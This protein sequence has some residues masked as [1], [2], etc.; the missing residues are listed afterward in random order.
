MP[1]RMGDVRVKA[2]LTTAVDEDLVRRG[3]LT[4]EQ[5]RT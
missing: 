1:S 4:P 5:V 2:R 3:M